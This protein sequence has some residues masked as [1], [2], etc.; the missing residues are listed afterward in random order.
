[1]LHRKKA[2]L[3]LFTILYD[4]DSVF[5]VHPIKLEMEKKLN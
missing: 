1:M 2:A 4:S 5:P 3:P